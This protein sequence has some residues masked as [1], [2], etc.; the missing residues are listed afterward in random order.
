MADLTFLGV[1]EINRIRAQRWHKGFPE[2]ESD[3]TGAD[4][5]NAMCGEAGET[6]NVVKKIRRIDTGI[7][8]VENPKRD[9]LIINKLA[10]EIGD[11]YIY[12]DL[13]AQYY[14]LSIESCVT[15]A[16]NQTSE[17]E[18]FPERIYVE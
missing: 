10:K 17:K 4:W 9:E 11:V 1:S 16:F 6:A 8:Q 3:W 18:G 12:L 2:G 7:Q 14:G 5:S 13:L 15:F